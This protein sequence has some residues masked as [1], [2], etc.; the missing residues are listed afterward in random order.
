M[1][2]EIEIWKECGEG[3]RCF[4]EVSN[5]GRVRSIIKKTKIERILK[6]AQNSRGYLRVWI[7]KKKILIH[8]LVAYAFLGPR[9]D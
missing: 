5:F 2:E 8:H 9:P 4:Y 1:E 7:E 6:G 3:K